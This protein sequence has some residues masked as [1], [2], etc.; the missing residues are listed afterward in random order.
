MLLVRIWSA[1]FSKYFAGRVLKIIKPEEKIKTLHKHCSNNDWLL[2]SN[3][4]YKEKNIFS[5]Y[6]F[7]PYK[8]FFPDLL[9]SKESCSGIT[10][11]IQ[12]VNPPKK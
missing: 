11:R 9:M 5:Y 6:I 1:I 3:S 2:S 8:N 7:Y 10:R 4:K 12:V